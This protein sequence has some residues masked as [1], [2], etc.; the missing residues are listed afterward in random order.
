MMRFHLP[1]P[2]HGWRSF[3]NEIVIVVIGVL[4]A[5]AAGQLVQDYN[6]RREV[7]HV[8]TMLRAE[9]YQLVQFMIERLINDRCE[10]ER[11]SDLRQK[12]QRSGDQW[13]GD[14]LPWKGRDRA[15][16]FARV[17]SA[18]LRPWSRQAWAM[19]ASSDVVRHMDPEKAAEYAVWY[20]QIDRLARINDDEAKAARHLGPLAFD[21]KLDKRIIM[22]MQST[23]ADLDY[24]NDRMANG[25]RQGLAWVRK[26]RFG[27]SP[28]QLR[29]DIAANLKL[30]REMRGNCVSD[31]A[32]TL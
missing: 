4:I 18:P 1:E 3:V 31:V 15:G 30:S 24:M 21:Q 16:A 20:T 26:M 32:V 27:F 5:L 6:E 23:L 17:Y 9:V 25:S 7:A 28:Q 2:P 10:I 22:D 11:L 8:E 12:L 29:A 19:A 13:T 14:P